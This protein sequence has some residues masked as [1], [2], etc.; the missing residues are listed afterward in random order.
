MSVWAE[1]PIV[2]IG[3]LFCA[4]K[5]SAAGARA[6]HDLLDGHYRVEHPDEWDGAVLNPRSADAVP[7]VVSGGAR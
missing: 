7:A 1:F 3:C 2:T 6:A 4:D 5:V